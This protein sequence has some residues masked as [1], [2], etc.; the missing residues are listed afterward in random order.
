MLERFLIKAGPMIVIHPESAGI[1]LAVG[2]A[3]AVY[4]LIDKCTTCVH[5]HTN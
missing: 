3:L 4:T 2:T 1:I 5:T